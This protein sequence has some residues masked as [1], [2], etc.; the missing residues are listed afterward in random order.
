[1]DYF[2]KFI[3]GE[4]DMKIKNSFKLIKQNNTITPSKR[5]R[6]FDDIKLSVESFKKPVLFIG[7]CGG[8]ASGKKMISEYFNHHIKNSETICEMS[9]FN[10]EEKNRKISK[11]DEYLIKD[12]DFYSKERRL[13]LIDR[14]NPD[15]YDYD[16]FYETLKNL[17]ERKEVK[18]PYFD[19]KNQKFDHKKDKTIDPT[20]TPLIIIDGYF[21]FRNQKIRDF[22][23]LKIYKEVEDD[24]RLSR[25]VL[26][27]A[28]YLKNKYEAYELYFSIY[29][30]FYKVCYDEYISTYK[31]VANILLP[32]YNLTEDNEVEGDETLEFLLSNLINYSQRTKTN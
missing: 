7:I 6:S 17:S 21:I 4:Q 18:I 30:K 8:Q 15:S 24:I 14:C 22:L 11:E 3:H 19:E 25:L 20:K 1:M 13:Y 26:R 9:F 32:D 12:N 5:K 10:P 2:N 31:K 28:N 23:N 29:E 16:K 27:E